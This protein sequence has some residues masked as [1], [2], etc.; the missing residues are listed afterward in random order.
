MPV[1]IRIRN[2]ARRDSFVKWKL[3]C[4]MFFGMAAC[5]E[6]LVSVNV[7]QAFP[8]TSGRRS[9]RTS[10]R[11]LA[12]RR[13]QVLHKKLSLSGRKLF[14]MKH[15]QGCLRRK[16]LQEISCL[17]K[18]DGQYACWMA[19]CQGWDIDGILVRWLATLQS[20]GSQT[21]PFLCWKLTPWSQQWSAWLTISAHPTW[22]LDWPKRQQNGTSPSKGGS[23]SSPMLPG[24]EVTLHMV[25]A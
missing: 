24:S 5:W 17:L 21:D 3:G 4:S 19:C 22:R 14:Q 1:S 15:R 6:N 12:L 13:R 8:V 10:R 23:T 16:T 2:A 7:C 11:C 25:P 20:G 9:Q 18:R